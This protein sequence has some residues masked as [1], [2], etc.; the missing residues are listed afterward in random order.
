MID[1]LY[2]DEMNWDESRSFTRS[3]RSDLSNLNDNEYKYFSE[4]PCEV[5]KC[6]T[7]YLQ[8]RALGRICRFSTS[9]TH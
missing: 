3:K 8:Q 9:R 2:D 1:G 5:Q 4:R 7:R 6:F